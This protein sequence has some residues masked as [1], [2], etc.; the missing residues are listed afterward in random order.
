MS[1]AKKPT[2]ISELAGEYGIDVSYVA[3]LVKKHKLE[4]VPSTTK[5]GKACKALPD[6]EVTKLEKAEPT[7]TAGVFDG[8]KFITLADMATD[9]DRDPAGLHKAIRNA[10]LEFTYLRVPTE[11][12]RTIK[13]EGEKAVKEIVVCSGKAKPC[14]TKAQYAKFKAAHTRVK[15]G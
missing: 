10:G 12:T 14:L 15:L 8:E 4:I 6:K 13:R 9:M 7:L 11:R 2:A 1:V 5:E 3:K